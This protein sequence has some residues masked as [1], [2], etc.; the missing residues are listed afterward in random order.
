MGV[1]AGGQN[2][3]VPVHLCLLH[4]LRDGAGAR[5]VERFYGQVRDFLKAAEHVWGNAWGHAAYMVTRP[6]TLK[7]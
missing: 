7:A 2:A 3:S 4:R 6:V 1:I 5:E